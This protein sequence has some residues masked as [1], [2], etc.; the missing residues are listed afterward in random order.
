VSGKTTSQNRKPILANGGAGDIQVVE[1]AKLKSDHLYQR[2]LIADVVETIS[3][4][5][6]IVTAGTIVVS[7]RENGD[8]FI[9]DGQHRVA[10]AAHAGETHILAQVLTGLT[11]REEADLR[12]KG[13]FKRTDRI[14]E[15][16]RARVFAGDPI[17]NKMQE[18]VAEFGTKINYS[19]DASRGINSVTAIEVILKEDPSGSSLRNVLSLIQEAWGGLDGGNANAYVLKGLSWFIARHGAESDRARLVQRLTTE[20]PGYLSRTA[21]NYKAAMGGSMWINTYRAIVEAYNTG[22]RDSSKLEFRTNRHTSRGSTGD[23]SWG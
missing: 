3:Q 18:I 14:W 9:V 12:L 15:V 21:R 4:N 8:M 11:P 10:G 22:L 19:P 1:L 17:A 20:G 5:Y 6:D 2:D 13:N 16:F 23:T 7:L